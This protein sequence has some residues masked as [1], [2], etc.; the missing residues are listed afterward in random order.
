M[1]K[2]QQRNVEKLTMNHR[3]LLSFVHSGNC[4]AGQRRPANAAY[5]GHSVVVAGYASTHIIKVAT[6]TSGGFTTTASNRVPDEGT[7]WIRHHGSLWQHPA[8]ALPFFDASETRPYPTLILPPVKVPAGHAHVPP[9]T[10]TLFSYR[11][12]P[13]PKPTVFPHPSPWFPLPQYILAGPFFL[14]TISTT[15][16]WGFEKDEK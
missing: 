7:I 16:I 4:C 1:Y 15:P 13:A 14:H 11:I 3:H 10:G 9:A 5:G 12:G 2:R 8:T 6:K